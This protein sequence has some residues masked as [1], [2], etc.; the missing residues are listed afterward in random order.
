MRPGKKK[1]RSIGTS[2]TS[3]SQ[4]AL[5]VP[6]YRAV[7]QSPAKGSQVFELAEAHLKREPITAS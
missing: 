5:E 7:L 3:P 6:F 1:G 2:H 4:Q